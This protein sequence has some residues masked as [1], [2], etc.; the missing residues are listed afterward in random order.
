M[1]DTLYYIRKCC[2]RLFFWNDGKDCTFPSTCTPARGNGCG[3]G[4]SCR[5]RRTSPEICPSSAGYRFRWFCLYPWYALFYD[6][7]DNAL[8]LICSLASVGWMRLDGCGRLDMF[9][10]NRYICD[11]QFKVMSRTMKY[12]AM[13]VLSL[14][15]LLTAGI[16]THECRCCGSVGLVLPWF[17][18]MIGDDAS[19]GGQDGLQPVADAVSLPCFPDLAVAESVLPGTAAFCGVPALPPSL[20]L[21]KISQYRL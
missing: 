4:S 14:Y 20:I 13:P 3:A 12:L 17:I 18:A 10:K 7:K 16:G 1:A 6:C 2:L 21:S 15:I 9:G 5:C 8:S 11:S 19:C